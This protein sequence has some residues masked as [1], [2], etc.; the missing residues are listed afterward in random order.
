EPLTEIMSSFV[1]SYRD[2]PSYVYQFQ[3]KFRNELR[4]KSG[5]MRGREF[6]MKDLYSFSG[7][8]EE[9]DS[10]YEQ[11]KA[12]YI[13]I[14]NRVGL[15][16]HTFVT[17]ASGGVFSKY[18]H[19]FQ[20]LTEA[21]EDTIYLSRDKKIAVNK[22]V[23]SDEVLEQLDLK[24][25]ELEEV[26]AVEV[27]NIFSLGT[28][29]SSALGLS[30]KDES[31]E[32]KEVIMG[33]YGIGLGRV[34]GTVVEVLSDDKGIV[35]PTSIAPFS[36]H[37][38]TLGNSEKVKNESE[39]LYKDS[40]LRGIEVL[41]DDRDVSNGEKFNDADL[42]GIP[43]QVIVSERS[44]EAGG[45]EIKNRATGESFI[46]QISDIESLVQAKA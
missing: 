37:I 25:D 31:G 40:G 45:F 20:T 4:A 38:L 21:G 17:F 14:F 34:M 10:F 11:A 29:F 23:F 6:L 7:T 9:H 26:R 2:L 5:I 22:E 15:G 1:N 33:S 8:Q 18:S 12:A 36:F 28:R 41:L 3:T 16:N 46:G 35:W 39:Q 43:H 42:I 44:L 13:N 30:Y 24:K 32:D 27:G 19:E